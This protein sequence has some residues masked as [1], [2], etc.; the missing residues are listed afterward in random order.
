MGGRKERKATG[1][2]NSRL[3]IWKFKS[4]LLKITMVPFFHTRFRLWISYIT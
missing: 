2:D 1:G 4:Y 3:D